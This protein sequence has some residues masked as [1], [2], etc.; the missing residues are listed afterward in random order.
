MLSSRKKNIQIIME[1]IR[2][3]LNIFL[4]SGY[5]FCT[6]QGVNSKIKPNFKYFLKPKLSSHYNNDLNNKKI[7]KTI[8]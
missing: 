2:M 8:N 5:C 1:Q 3:L 7:V 6:I 4:Q